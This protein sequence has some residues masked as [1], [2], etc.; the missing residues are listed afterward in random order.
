M[1][2]HGLHET[3]IVNTTQDEEIISVGCSLLANQRADS[4]SA[5]SVC[6]LIAIGNLSEE[7]NNRSVKASIDHAMVVTNRPASSETDTK[8]VNRI[9]FD[10]H[11]T[12]WSD[13]NLLKFGTLVTLSSTLENAIFYP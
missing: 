5:N 10:P 8:D 12:K 4:P 6:T 1:I 7:F 13:V 9:H 2:T 11:T 3:A